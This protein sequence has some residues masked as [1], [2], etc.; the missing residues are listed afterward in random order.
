[1]EQALPVV[2]AMI[3]VRNEQRYIRTAVR[4]FLEQDY[5]A[6]CLELLI[7][8]GMSSDD[9]VQAAHEAVELCRASGRDI[10][11]RYLENPKLNLAAGWNLG[12]REARGEYVVRIDAHAE[13]DRQMIR[14]C[15]GILQTHPDVA[16]AGGRIEAQPL[17]D[18]G[19]IISFVQSSP[20]G[21]GNAKFR[22]SRE[23]GYVD[24]VAYGVYRKSIFEKAGYFNEAFQRN[25]DNDMHGRIKAHGGKFYLDAT[26]VS[27]YHPRET[28]KGM[29]K[30]GFGNGKWVIIGYRKSEKKE[31]LSLRH[32]IPL[33]FL[34]A[35]IILIIG[36]IFLPIVRWCFA[37][38]YLAYL[39]L[40][41]YFALQ[42]TKNFAEVLQW[43]LAVWLFHVSYGAGS[44]T[45]LFRRTK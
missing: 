32:M 13:A 9:T 43:C 22:Y 5:P 33:L 38:M 30:Q 44:L 6:E 15:V 34:A 23:S 27:L 4:S 10:P 14:K 2:T 41:V 8:D 45:Q 35:N 11:V 12:I 29:M 16:C 24:T 31:G 25:Q 21:V 3:V 7:I 39:V 19:K 36:G 18:K 37:A 42:K 20:F 28:L 26:V 17:T 1:M 40:A